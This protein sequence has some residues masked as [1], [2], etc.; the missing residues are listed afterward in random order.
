MAARLGSA[1]R[2]AHGAAR[3][4]VADVGKRYREGQPLC[5]VTAYDLFSGAVGRAAGADMLLVGDSLANVMLGF[6]DTAQATLQDMTRAV[7]AVKRG[8]QR[9]GG[10]GP[11]PLIVGDIPFVSSVGAT[12]QDAAQLVVHG[13]DCVK[14]EG[15]SPVQLAKV[16]ELV[17]NGISVMAHIGLVRQQRKKKK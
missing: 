9:Q 14:L 17:N 12:L 10:D 4:T 5:M 16:R 3:L 1:R 11:M 13:A 2:A 8:M 6:E 7:G 15:A